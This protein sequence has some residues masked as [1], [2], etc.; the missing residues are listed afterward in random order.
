[1]MCSEKVVEMEKKA[2]EPVTHLFTIRVWQ[3]PCCRRTPVWHLR[4]HH[5]NSGNISFSTDLDHVLDQL[6]AALG[7]I[8]D[9]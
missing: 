8:D 3:E 7:S 2:N 6:K 4:F 9:E 5:V 1:M